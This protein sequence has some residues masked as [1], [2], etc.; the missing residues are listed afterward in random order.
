MRTNDIRDITPA[1]HAN[2]QIVVDMV[3]FFIFVS[4]KKEN[5]KYEFRAS[6]IYIKNKINKSNEL[7]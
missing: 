3:G 4:K 1:N 7:K 2:V 5:Y 6:D